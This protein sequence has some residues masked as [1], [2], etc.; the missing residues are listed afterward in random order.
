MAAATPPAGRAASRTKPLQ[1]DK[2]PSGGFCFGLP[3]VRLRVMKTHTQGFLLNAALLASTTILAAYAGPKAPAMS[4]AE[5]ARADSG[6]IR[7]AIEDIKDR[8]REQ[9]AAFGYHGPN[10]QQTPILPDK[11]MPDNGQDP[12]GRD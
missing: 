2:S 3:R 4:A 12:D 8:L 9:D 5:Q 6:A 7:H 11:M 1:A 10:S